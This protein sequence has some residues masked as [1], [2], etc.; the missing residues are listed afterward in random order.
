[1]VPGMGVKLLRD[2]RDSANFVCMYSVDGQDSLN[3]FAHDFSNHTPT[4]RDVFFKLLGA[5]FETAS[6]YIQ[7]VGLSEMAS[8]DQEG[9]VEH[10]PLFPWSLRFT[11]GGA[12][13]F[14]ETAQANESF[15]TQLATIAP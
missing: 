12:Y 6:D 15:M 14:P 10:S 2:G 1:M 5:R 11:P 3:W 8:V 4:P 9:K 7:T 13:Q